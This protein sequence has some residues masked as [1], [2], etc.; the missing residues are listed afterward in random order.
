[1]TVKAKVTSSLSSSM[2]NTP[3]SIPADDTLPNCAPGGTLTPVMLGAAGI[4]KV[5]FV[6]FRRIQP[7]TNPGLSDQK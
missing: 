6:V 4:V 7:S 2:L 1:M 5:V 3:S